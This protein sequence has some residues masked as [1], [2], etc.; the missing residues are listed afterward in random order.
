M[1]PAMNSTIQNIK[2][3]ALVFF[4]ATGVLHLGSSIFIANQIF[5]K[6]AFILNRTMDIPFVITGMIYALASL[7]LGLTNPS[8]EHKK[9]DIALASVVILITL[10]LILIN[11]ILPDLK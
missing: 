6:P 8:S 9:L 10:S 7:R 5:T 1:G 4:I 3:V 11:I 2:K